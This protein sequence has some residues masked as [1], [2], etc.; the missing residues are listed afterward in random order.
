M[1]YNNTVKGLVNLFICFGQKKIA[2]LVDDL[3]KKP[4]S[5]L[6]ERVGALSQLANSFNSIIYASSMSL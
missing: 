6:N 2:Q 1:L 4:F 3:I 5:E